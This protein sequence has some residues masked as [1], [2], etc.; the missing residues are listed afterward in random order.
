MYLQSPDGEEGKAAINDLIL[1]AKKEGMT[2]SASGA[3]LG[4]IDMSELSSYQPYLSLFYDYYYMLL[5]ICYYKKYESEL[6]KSLDLDNYISLESKLDQEE[7]LGVDYVPPEK[8]V[9]AAE[10]GKRLRRKKR[11]KKNE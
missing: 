3:E 6:I 2:K 1:K 7:Q 9:S 4:E 11:E 5:S 10:F 8:R